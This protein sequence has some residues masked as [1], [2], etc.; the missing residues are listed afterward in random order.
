MTEAVTLLP[1]DW[2]NMANSLTPGQ[3]SS[4]VKMYCLHSPVLL[5]FGLFFQQERREVIL[6]LLQEAITGASFSEG[7]G[8]VNLLLVPMQIQEN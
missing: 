2:A 5:V 3:H 4:L 6:S 7:A 1:Q 8:R